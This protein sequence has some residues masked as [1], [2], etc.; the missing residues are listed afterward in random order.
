MIVFDL[1]GAEGR[2]M[3]VVILRWPAILLFLLIR[4]LRI[5]LMRL[6]L[7]LWMIR[8]GVLS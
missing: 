2:L 7:I 5:S 1:V 3:L 4:P 6:I 8:D